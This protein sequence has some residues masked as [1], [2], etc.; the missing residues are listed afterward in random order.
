LA[1]TEGV[2]PDDQAYCSTL[3]NQ[4]F[5]TDYGITCSAVFQ[6]N[7]THLAN[8]AVLRVHQPLRI[9]AG[10]GTVCGFAQRS[11]LARGPYTGTET[12]IS[13]WEE[14]PYGRCT[15]CRMGR[16]PLRGLRLIGEDNIFTITST[17][18]VRPTRNRSV[19]HLHGGE[20][21]NGGIDFDGEYLYCSPRIP[22]IP[23]GDKTCTPQTQEPSTWG[24][25]F[26]RRLACPEGGG[27]AFRPL[28]TMKEQVPEAAIS[29]QHLQKSYGSVK[30]VSDLSFWAERGE[31][32]HTGPHGRA[33]HHA[34]NHAWAGDA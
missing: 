4:F 21:V 33:S 32:S 16:L 23:A 11:H 12:G 27:P 3:R 10:H 14:I 18:T 1:L 19:H 31:I 30:A 17:P 15:A 26:I 29:V 9:G 22:S 7:G 13:G 28:S 20:S 5:M 2:D 24:N 8:I 6:E 25:I 34:E